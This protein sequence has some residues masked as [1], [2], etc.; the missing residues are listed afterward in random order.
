MNVF[1]PAK[2]ERLKAVSIIHVLMLILGIFFLYGL[3]GPEVQRS[4]ERKMRVKRYQCQSN[5][6]Q[7][8][9]AISYTAAEHLYAGNIQANAAWNYFQ[10]VG[11]HLTSPKVLICPADEGRIE[12]AADFEAGPKSFASTNFQNRALSFFY[13]PYAT[14]SD[15]YS[16]VAGDRNVSTN[17]QILSGA[18]TFQT[19]HPFQ[20][21]T[22]I[23]RERG[24]LLLA[25]GSAQQLTSGK[26]RETLML[27][28]PIG[29]QWRFMMP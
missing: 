1:D 15:P 9:Q 27:T 5:L 11:T 22:N 12:G 4:R 18:V 19:N 8:G 17:A 10:A 21:T 7:I 14:K 25:D 2:R 3:I 24:N 16:P 26:L 23:H 13:N 6:K 29:G 28:A 20:W